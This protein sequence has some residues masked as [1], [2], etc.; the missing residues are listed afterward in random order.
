MALPVVPILVVAGAAGLA[1]RV[2]LSEEVTCEIPRYFKVKAKGFLFR[3]SRQHGG[4]R[5]FSD[6]TRNPELEA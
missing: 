6:Q 1:L 4:A 3:R 2:L 5:Q